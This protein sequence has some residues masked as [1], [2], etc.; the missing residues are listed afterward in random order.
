VSAK[1]AASTAI[2]VAQVAGP[3]SCPTCGSIEV[4]RFAHHDRSTPAPFCL[5]CKRRIPT[6]TADLRAHGWPDDVSRIKHHFLKPF[7]ARPLSWIATDEG[8]R[9]LRTWAVGLRTHTAKRDKKPLGTR[10]V[11]NV[12]YAVK[13]LLDQAVELER[14][15]R[16]PLAT[17]RADKYLPAKS[18]KGPR[19][20][21]FELE[22]VVSLTT[23]QR[24]CPQ[25]LVWNTLA[26]MVGGGRTGEIANLRWQDWS[27]SHIP[28]H[29]F[30]GRVLKESR[31]KGWKKLMDREPEPE[32]FIVP[33]SDG[34]QLPNWKLGEQFYADL[35]VPIPRQRQYENRSTFR[36][37]LICAG[38]P[39][40]I[41]NLIPT[42][43]PSRPA[44]STRASRCN[45]RRCAQR[46]GCSITRQGVKSV[47]ARCRS[48][49]V[50]LK[51]LA[52]R[53]ESK[54][55]PNSER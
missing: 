43:R 9:A 46:S 45:G 22:Q 34:K 3:P 17:F 5:T 8:A 40:F 28:I 1:S 31:E 32:D 21:G 24:L 55:A 13:V 29:P 15:E 6:I 12:F 37:L 42:R 38:A 51:P 33:G 4:V 2:G 39:E 44:T 41:V 26:F 14:L 19:P 49:S 7:G 53:W 30:A 27:E 18:D 20:A 48:Q 54:K 52:N 10:T 23:D 36:N 50:S 25:R 35:D 47:S 16:N 11:W